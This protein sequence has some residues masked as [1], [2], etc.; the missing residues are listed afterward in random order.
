MRS[1]V[2]FALICL[3][4]APLSP[5][6][7]AVYKYIDESGRTVFVDGE[8]RI[9]ARYRGTSTQ[10]QA[11]RPAAP[12]ASDE[13]APA[14]GGGDT[15]AEAAEPAEP[16][17]PAARTI[18]DRALEQRARQEVADLER[19]RAYQ[20]PVMVRGNRVMVPVEIIV[21]GKSAHLMLQ[22]DDTTPITTIHRSA[23]QELRFPA[24]EQIDLPGSGNRTIK[25]EKV[26]AGMIDIGPFEL[27]DFPLALVT[28]QGGSRA[29]DGTLGADFLKGHPYSVDSER[30]MLRW[31][32]PGK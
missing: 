3:M 32:P 25:A 19:A 7:A 10:V 23:V 5:A 24:G 1:S 16:A 26:L 9:P 13:T 2:I 31:Q 12:E 17:E 4:L 11:A 8:A 29:F 22:L 15:K 20:T 18:T 27:K 21:G 6:A 14:S 28:P 30:E